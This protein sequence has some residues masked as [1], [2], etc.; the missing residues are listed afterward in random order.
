M[1]KISKLLYRYYLPRILKRGCGETIPSYED[2]KVNCYVIKIL[3]EHE[4]PM[5]I[6][7]I[8]GEQLFVISYHGDTR[9]TKSFS[10]HELDYESIEITHHHRFSMPIVY[11][12][13]YYFSFAK[14]SGYAFLKIWAPYTYRSL[15]ISFTKKKN[16]SRKL[17]SLRRIELLK[18]LWSEYSLVAFDPI[19]VLQ[20]EHSV[21]AFYRDD[22]YKLVDKEE[23]YLEIL[24]ETGDLRITTDKKYILT[25]QALKTIEEYYLNRRRSCWQTFIA[26]IAILLT[27]LQLGLVKFPTVW[28]FRS[29]SEKQ[30]TGTQ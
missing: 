5:V 14:V 26:V 2:E 28:D 17:T 29:E 9:A 6:S 4:S 21:Y 8:E 7:K 18:N 1:Y 22:K 11:R 23:R 25:G 20:L 10:F 19:D 16:I 30:T 12:N 27:F 13:I 15:L 24:V 3:R